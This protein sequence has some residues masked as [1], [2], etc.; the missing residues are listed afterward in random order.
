MKNFAEISKAFSTRK[1]VERA[2]LK[3]TKTMKVYE[4]ISEVPTAKGIE[5]RVHL[6]K[7]QC[8]K[9]A[10]KFQREHFE[11]DGVEVYNILTVVS[12]TP[13]RGYIA[14]EV[15]KNAHIIR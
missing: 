6:V 7:T 5:Q 14:Y 1:K 3:N 9:L 4:V 8:P 15:V 11:K 10:L 2:I 12:P 13:K